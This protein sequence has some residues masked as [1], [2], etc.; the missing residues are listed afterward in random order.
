MLQAVARRIA[1]PGALGEGDPRA[2]VLAAC[3]LGKVAI[4]LPPSASSFQRTGTTSG[5]E[6]RCPPKSTL[7]WD[8]Q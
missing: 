3:R 1:S 7:S 8:A 4:A 6:G 5:C 2:I